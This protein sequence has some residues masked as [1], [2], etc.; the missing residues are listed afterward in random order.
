[1]NDT[2]H[3]VELPTNTVRVLLVAPSLGIL[4]GQAIQ[5]SRLV[6]KFRQE[7]SLQIGFQPIDPRLP[8]AFG[9]LQ[10]IKYVRT[11]VTSLMYIA[12][13][14]ARIPRYDV[15]HIF[16][17]SFSSFVIAPTPAI[18]LAKLFGKPSLLNYRSGAAV[19]HLRTW[20]T[21][22][23]T[24]RLVQRIIAPS[25][26][27]VDEFA[28]FNLKAEAIYNFVDTSRFRF[29][30]RDRLRPAFLS[31]RNHEKHYNVA[32][33]LRAF[34]FIQNQHPAASLVVAGDGVERLALES[35]SRE[36]QLENVSFIGRVMPEDM[37]ALYDGAD[38]YLNAPDWDNMPGSIIEAYA[39]GI[40]IVT[41][42]AGGIPYI[43]THEQTALMIDCD[44][45]EAMS[46][47]AL[48]LLRDEKLATGI[49]A[50]GLTECR[51]YAW[52][53]VREDWLNLYR[54]LRDESARGE[55]ASVDM[56]SEKI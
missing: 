46:R 14:L 1:M 22:L 25:G 48:R 24:I 31:N 56:K 12:Q 20:K 6:E 42:N 11:V 33:I 29:R 36:L 8:G 49:A 16:S 50:N 39:S 5:A 37:P 9:K 17:A 13:L 30:R 34:R 27:L 15:I 28:Q 4:G 2:P 44:D 21:A 7:K 18:L 26:Y 32:C 55:L 35:L 52:E 51:K 53:A 47:E 43:V 10:N 40:P 3:T 38:I 54:T 19:N 23:P 41:T 45:H